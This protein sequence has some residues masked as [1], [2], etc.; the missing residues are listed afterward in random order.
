MG[1]GTSVAISFG[2]KREKEAVKIKTMLDLSGS[3]WVVMML[4][5]LVAL[6][7][8]IIL[9]FMGNWWSRWWVW[10][11][12]ILMLGITIWMFVVG[13]STYHPLRRTLGMPYMARGREMPAEEPASEEESQ[14]LIA[15]TSPWLMLLIGYGG[16]VLVIWLMMF[17]PF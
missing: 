9:S 2:L 13:Q 15:K 5:M 16:F 10:V 14:A 1:H 17:K 7:A 8:G 6:I 12:L 11:S 4:S 3:L